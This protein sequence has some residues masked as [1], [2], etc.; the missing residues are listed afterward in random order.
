MKRRILSLL[1]ALCLAA[2]LAL[3]A[4][5]AS[6][7]ALTPY[8]TANNGKPYY[9]MVNRAM[10]TVTVYAVGK[11]GNYSLPIKAMPC[12]VGDGVEGTTPLGTFTLPGARYSWL[13]MY[14]DVYTQYATRIQDH[15]LFHSIPYDIKSPDTLL[16]RQY[17]KLGTPASMGCIRLQ[18]SDAKWIYDNCR[19]GTLV[20]IYDDTSTPGPLGKPQPMLSPLRASGAKAKWDPSDSK[21]D[22]PWYGQV[23]LDVT[24][25]ETSLTLEPGQTHTLTAAITPA[26]ATIPAAATWASSDPSVVSVDRAGK[27]IAIAPGQ[28]RIVCSYGSLFAWCSVTV[29]PYELN[30]YASTQSVNINGKPTQFQMYAL[31]DELGNDTNYIRAR[32]LAIALMDTSA[33]FDVGYVDRVYMVT[34]YPY[35]RVGEVDTVPFSGD[36]PCQRLKSQ[37]SVN[38][39][40]MDLGGIILHDSSGGGYT[41]YKLRDLGQALGFEVDWTA[42]EG[43]LIRTGDPIV[44]EPT[45]TPE[46]TPEPQA[47]SEPDAVPDVTPE[48]QATPEPDASPAPEDTAEPTVSPT[49]AAE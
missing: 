46:T 4:L 6:D 36:H 7:E 43:V 14:H 40:L 25:S 26:S 24:L 8:R 16:T 19:A 15:V 47:T 38:G 39:V 13:F 1:M 33:Q 49:A 21:T 10:N 9:I 35:Y 34:G 44:T 22:N 30:A 18:C 29:E 37:T 41:Y 48:P 31:R 3:P 17:N 11:D 5:A 28:A 27:L 23:V 42:Q 12:S 32:D 45:P 2:G 20:T